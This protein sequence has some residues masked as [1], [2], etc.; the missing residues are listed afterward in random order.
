FVANTSAGV[1]G[2]ALPPVPALADR[3][4]EATPMECINPSDFE[5]RQLIQLPQQQNPVTTPPPPLATTLYSHT[6]VDDPRGYDVGL[7]RPDLT[8][9]Q[10]GAYRRPITTTSEQI[11]MIEMPWVTA[12]GLDADAGTLS[13]AVD[14]VDTNAAIE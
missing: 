3:H 12:L 10:S 6:S 14:H 2:F 9:A 13:V 11:D 7:S 5:H 1:T 4:L 8:S